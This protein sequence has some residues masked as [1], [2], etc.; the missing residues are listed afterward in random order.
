MGKQQKPTISVKA[1][2]QDVSPRFASAIRCE[3][4]VDI[5]RLDFIYA[6]KEVGVMLGRYAITPQHAKRLQDLLNRQIGIYEKQFG[7]IELPPPDEKSKPRKSKHAN[8]GT[9]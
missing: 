3:A 2:G 9:R 4:S 8:N 1:T 5:F 6:D 7:S